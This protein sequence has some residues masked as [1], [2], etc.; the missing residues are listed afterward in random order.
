MNGIE[1]FGAFIITTLVFILTPG[2][3]TVFVLNK[4]I[5]Q[6]K[7]AGVY[8]SL[9]INGGII[10]HTLF[11]ALGL[12]I[13]VAKS[14]TA[15]MVIKY[16]GAIYLVYLGI[17][18]ILSKKNT[19]INTTEE[20]GSNNMQH[21]FSGLITNIFNPKVALFFLSFFLSL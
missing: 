9:G 4:S 12:S 19:D 21:F 3:D 7:K 20:D 14:A 13:I 15:F 18:K 10:M 17:T 11:A 1:H 16:F 8:A 2:I 6:G 5:G